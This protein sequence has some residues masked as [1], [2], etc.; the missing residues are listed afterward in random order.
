ML[1]PK[2]LPSAHHVRTTREALGLT[3][4]EFAKALGFNQYQTVSAW[5]NGGTP[6]ITRVEFDRRVARIAAARGDVTA[7]GVTAPDY[8]RSVLVML[9]GDAEAVALIAD[10]MR[11]KIRDALS[12]LPDGATPRA[13]PLA[14]ER[15]ARE[16]LEAAARHAA[17]AAPRARR[18]R[19]SQ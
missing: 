19:K 1:D 7:Q 9:E 13:D 17:P 5:E 8:A 10:R 11:G 4:T 14:V 2:S 12:L 16:S 3:Q 18:R 6:S 15:V